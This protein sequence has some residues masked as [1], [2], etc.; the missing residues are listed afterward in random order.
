MNGPFNRVIDAVVSIATNLGG[1]IS[2]HTGNR[3]ADALEVIA[4]YAKNLKGGGLPAV[5]AT[6]NGKVLKVVEGAWALGDDNQQLL[7]ASPDTA[8]NYVLGLHDVS[9]TPTLYWKEDEEAVTP[10]G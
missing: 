1:T 10:G 5:T 7:P 3:L 6:N 4:N 9:G 8:G 2:T